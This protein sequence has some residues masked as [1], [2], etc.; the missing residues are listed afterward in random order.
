MCSAARLPFAVSVQPWRGY[1]P[2]CFPA[3]FC[4]SMFCICSLTFSISVFKAMARWEMSRLVDL[5]RMVLD[6]RFISWAIKSSFRPTLPPLFSSV[7]VALMWL[8]RRT[9]S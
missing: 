9:V 8:R 6:S 5:L 2:V 1:P 4:Y 7:L 3:A